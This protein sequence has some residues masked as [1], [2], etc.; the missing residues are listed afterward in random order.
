MGG[1]FLF[2][3]NGH[4]GIIATIIVAFLL[5]FFLKPE[6][7]R[8]L[9]KG[10][11]VFAALAAVYVGAVKVYQEYDIW[12]T[13][14]E[15][16]RMH[17]EAAEANKHF[18]E[19]FAEKGIPV[20][21][22]DRQLYDK[23]NTTHYRVKEHLDYWVYATTEDLTIVDV[24]YQPIAYHPLKKKDTNANDIFDAPEPIGAKK[25]VTS[26]T[27]YNPPGHWYEEGKRIMKKKY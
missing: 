16:E 25:K 6:F 3:I 4:F 19:I 14:L 1:G 24:A 21:L 2:F 20:T 12:Q 7:R 18:R 22:S 23:Y 5:Y 13:N 15:N 11:L 10:L 9:L 17:A 26:S 27:L 8:K